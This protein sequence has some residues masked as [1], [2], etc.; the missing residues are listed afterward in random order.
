[1][2]AVPGRWLT[3]PANESQAE[4]VFLGET[5]SRLVLLPRQVY[6]LEISDWV[7]EGELESLAQLRGLAGLQE[8][9]LGGCWQVTD[10]G[11]AHLGGLAGLQ[12]L[13]LGGCRLVTD[14][15]RTAL[16]AALPQCTIT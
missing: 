4:W 1:D 14:A 10:A 6:R 15:G 9:S 2:L 12:H 8:L 7:T 3:R 11:L 13:E 5:P 16:R